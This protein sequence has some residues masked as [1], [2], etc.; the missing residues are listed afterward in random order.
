MSATAPSVGKAPH[1]S[2]SGTHGRAGSRHG[3]DEAL[4]LSL[5]R[6]ESSAQSLCL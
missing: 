1:T 2:H 6:V 3:F 5:L 4:A